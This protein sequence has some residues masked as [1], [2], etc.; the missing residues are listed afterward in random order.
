MPNWINNTVFASGTPASLDKLERIIRNVENG[1]AKL[2]EQVDPCP[3]ELAEEKCDGLA[4]A[5]EE[6]RPDLV[7]V[8]E[9]ILWKP[10]DDH[11]IAETAR[12]ILRSVT[13][14]SAEQNGRDAERAVAF[15][16]A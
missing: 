15:L 16:T 11:E 1:S 3:K 13:V 7:E 2:F 5:I 14:G 4:M 12:R 8:L 9:S 10:D 6:D